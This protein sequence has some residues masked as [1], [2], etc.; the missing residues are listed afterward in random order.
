VAYAL[1]MPTT[2]ATLVHALNG[3]DGQHAARALYR[4]YGG[5]LYGFAY[6][7][8]RD[9]GL[10]E[11]LVQD[12]F[13]RVWRH[14]AEFDERQATVRTWLYAIAR[15]AVSDLERNRSRRP[16][17]AAHDT[18]AEVA[19]PDEPIETALLRYQIQMA[20][21]R[22]TA[23]HRQIISLVHFQ[24]MRL[25]DVAEFSGL[26]LGTV[27]SRLHY[28]SRSLRLTLEELGVTP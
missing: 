22:L 14:A 20:L 11:E 23:E 5:E 12:V 15:N 16:R 18:Q 26:P 28:A 1:Q 3:E 7:R 6:H 8:L 21:Q 4:I 2:D 27:K 10:A 25:S 19:A 17:L 13:T 9:R 24:G